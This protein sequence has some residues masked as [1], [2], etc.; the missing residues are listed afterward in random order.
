LA[1]FHLASEYPLPVEFC[2]FAKVATLSAH[3][4][5]SFPQIRPKLGISNASMTTLEHI[6][7]G[8]RVTTARKDGDDRKHRKT[9]N[10]MSIFFKKGGDLDG[11][12]SDNFDKNCMKLAHRTEHGT[13]TN[14]TGESRLKRWEF[15][16]IAP[17]EKCKQSKKFKIRR[18][19]Q[20]RDGK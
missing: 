5:A 17:I 13:F 3:R 14:K 4:S 8:E 6:R 11:Q 12:R 2:T 20:K 19:Q 15:P 10:V 9:R 16:K 7:N 1:K 18:K